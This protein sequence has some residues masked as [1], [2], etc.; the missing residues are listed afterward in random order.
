MLTVVLTGLY[1]R[2]PSS[3][4]SAEAPAVALTIGEP[5]TINLVFGARAAL[6]DVEFIVDLPPGIELA[7]HAGERRVTGRAALTAGDN[8]LPVT[9]VARD[10]TGGQ[11]AARLR[12][13]DQQKT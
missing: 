8:A 1:V 4:R 10:G 11:L 7:D 5:H 12:H 3:R 13:G 9:V 2:S 6:G